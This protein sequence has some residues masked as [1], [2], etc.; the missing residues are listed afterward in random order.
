MSYEE[1]EKHNRDATNGCIDC[2]IEEIAI[3]DLQLD[4]RA[5]PSLIESKHK[6]I[7]SAA[8]R[9]ITKCVKVLDLIEEYPTHA[10]EK[11]DGVVCSLCQQQSLRL[12]S[13]TLKEPFPFDMVC[14]SCLLLTHI[15]VKAGM[16][17]QEIRKILSVPRVGWR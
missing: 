11:C 2:E 8:L 6:E 4:R 12:I 16:H 17:E 9:M 1:C 13:N 7:R 5:F 10:A 15:A 14:Q 3:D